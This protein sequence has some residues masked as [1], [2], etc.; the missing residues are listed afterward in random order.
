MD[1]LRRPSTGGTGF[2]PTGTIDFLG[3]GTPA[4]SAQTQIGKNLGTRHFD[5]MPTG[6]TRRETLLRQSLL[7]GRG[8]VRPGPRRQDITKRGKGHDYT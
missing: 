1:G 5:L 6:L 3:E 4:Q 2:W 7:G 8:M